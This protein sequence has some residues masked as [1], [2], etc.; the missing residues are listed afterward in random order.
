MGMQRL[1]RF[2][3]TA[4]APTKRVRHI[5]AQSQFTCEGETSQGTP[6]ALLGFLEY[7]IEGSQIDMRR[8]FVDPAG[9]GQ[10]IAKLLCDEAF[11]F[12]KANSLQ[13]V[14]TCSYIRDNYL[15]SE[16]KST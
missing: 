7:K 4:V 1:L 14:P 16:R 8:T 5:P 2:S 6:T 11:N 13:V 15:K 10:G 12:A 3:T 9:R